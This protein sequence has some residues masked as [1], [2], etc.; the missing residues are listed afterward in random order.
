VCLCFCLHPHRERCPL[1]C[2]SPSPSSREMPC[3]SVFSPSPS[4]REVL[5]D[6]A[7]YALYANHSCLN[8]LVCP[9]SKFNFRKFIWYPKYIQFPGN[10]YN[11]SYDRPLLSDPFYTASTDLS[12]MINVF[13]PSLSVFLL[14]HNTT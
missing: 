10:L 9:M 11:A 12:D 14:L 3:V 7:L 4:L 1:V 6:Y 13:P 2:V 8:C 5:A